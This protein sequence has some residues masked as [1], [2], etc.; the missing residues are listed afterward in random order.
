MP[1]TCRIL[2][3]L[4]SLIQQ[5]LD[6]NSVCVCVCFMSVFPPPPPPPNNFQ[7]PFVKTVLNLLWCCILSF[8]NFVAFLFTLTF[9]TSVFHANVCNKISLNLL[10]RKYKEDVYFFKVQT[11]Y[12]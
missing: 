7:L 5:L 2:H 11:I 3:I 8:V 4:L 6:P 12:L 9:V 10:P 1:K